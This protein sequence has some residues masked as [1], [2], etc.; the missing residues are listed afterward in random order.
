MGLDYLHRICKIIHTDLKPE[1][2]IVSLTRPELEEIIKKGHPSTVNK[3]IKTF[4]INQAN[5][6]PSKQQ[7]T[8]LENVD[9]TGLTKQ[10]KKKLKKKLRKNQQAQ[11]GG[12]DDDSDGEQDSPAKKRGPL[13]TELRQLAADL[14]NEI[15]RPRSYS[16]PNMAVN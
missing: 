9:T 8:L 5:L 4:D 15:E 10:Q 1:N 2:V 7:K 13:P 12:S 11:G 3:N 6:L 14:N 16:L